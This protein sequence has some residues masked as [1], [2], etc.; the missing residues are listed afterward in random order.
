LYFYLFRNKIACGI[1]I[2]SV[3]NVYYIPTYAQING[4][5]L[6]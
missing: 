3:L 6:Y 1:E 2:Y 4:V 5:N